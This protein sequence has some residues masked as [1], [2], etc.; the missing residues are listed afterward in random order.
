MSIELMCSCGKLLRTK[1]ESAGKRIKCPICS[2]ILTVPAAEAS[3]AAPPAGDNDAI[4]V[5]LDWSGTEHHPAPDPEHAAAHEPDEPR[6]G[7]GK[8]YKVLTPKEYAVPGK[9]N[10]GK[11]EETL[12]ELA[13]K[14]WVV[15]SSVVINV[16][17]H[18]GAHDEL[19]VI[20]E[21]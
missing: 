14:G 4:A 8:S 20:L 19:V 6:S 1:D 7:S 2:A 16:V 10:P 9:F 5:N 21:R 11:L 12:N 13:S 15:R 3:V 17:G 18:A